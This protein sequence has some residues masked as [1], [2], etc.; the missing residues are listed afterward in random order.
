[1]FNWSSVRVC[2]C[3]ILSFSLALSLFPQTCSNFVLSLTFFLTFAWLLFFLTFAFCLVRA[4][5]VWW[6]G[7][8]V[9]LALNSKQLWLK[10]CDVTETHLDLLSSPK[11]KQVSRDNKT[12]DLTNP[13]RPLLIP[14]HVAHFSYFETALSQASF[15]ASS[16]QCVK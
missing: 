4:A 10:F 14:C 1:M 2:A 9:E 16:I 8:R 13:P 12:I 6:K 15:I 11:I 7:G 3:L 5:L